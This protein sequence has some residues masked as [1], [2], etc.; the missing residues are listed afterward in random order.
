MADKKITQLTPIVGADLVS[1]DEFVVVD[2]STDETKS[3]VLSELIAGIAALPKSGGAM[4]GAITTNSTFAGRD[5]ATDG[6]KLDTIETNATADQTFNQILSKTGGTGEYSTTGILTAGRNNGGVSMTVND[7][8][9]NAN[10][11]FNHKNGVPEQLGNGGRIVVNTDAT[12]APSMA[13]HIGSAVAAGVAYTAPEVMKLSSTGLNVTG[14]ITLG[15][16]VDGRDVA[17]DG[18]KL[19]GIEGGLVWVR[20]TSNY[21]SSSNDAVIA[22]TSGGVW[23]L[24]L[25]ALPSVGN[26]V[27]V[28]DGADWATN[29]LTV[30]R[31]SSTIEGDAADLVMNIGGVSV[32]FVYDGTTWQ[33]YIQ[34]GANSG[35]VV[36][37]TGTQTLTNKT[38]TSPTLT[39]PSITSPTITGTPTVPTATVGTDTTQAASTA[40]VLANAPASP[41]KAWVNFNG[42]GTVAIRASFN[43]SSITDNGTGDY[44]VNFAV[45]MTDA[46]FSYSHAYS[47]EVSGQH[48]VGFFES[49]SASTLRIRHFNA[50]NSSN[51]VNK[52]VV[53]IAVFR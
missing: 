26:L 51:R 24:T 25:P 8:Y 31:N 18:S 13:F 20:K 39:S 28:V 36:T 37:E 3:I 19:D 48:T 4:T 30:A 45:A 14:N 38:L 27:R 12:S 21:T 47:D 50:A 42:T 34:V 10:L 49:S 52:A 41:V 11:T 43:V 23:T 29:N 9:G 33:L 46:D 6:T 32:D 1:A 15:G 35:T 53:A 2:V 16:T 40:F 5:V 22:D 17:A 44:T 7:G